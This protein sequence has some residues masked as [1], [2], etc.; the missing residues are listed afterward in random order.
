MVKKDNCCVII[1]KF[2][3]LQLNNKVH[4]WMNTKYARHKATDDLNDSILE[5][6]DKFIEVYFGRYG[7]PKAIKDTVEFKSTTEKEYEGYLVDFVSFLEKE[8]PK[9]MKTTDTDLL[10]IRDELLAEINKTLY[11]F[12]LT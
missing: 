11:L 7:R 9:L 10:N 12:T 6:S 4:H 3:E 5:M 8:L 2:F 1:H